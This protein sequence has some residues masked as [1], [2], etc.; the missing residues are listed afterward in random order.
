MII[1][2][3]VQIGNNIQIGNFP[4][5]P[6]MTYIIYDN[7]TTETVDTQLFTESGDTLSIESVRYI[8]K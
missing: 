4:V 7:L 5:V 8:T 3:G 6:L 1:E 2:S